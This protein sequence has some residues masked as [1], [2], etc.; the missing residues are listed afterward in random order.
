VLQRFRGELQLLDEAPK[1][2][3]GRNSRDS[4]RPAF[5]GGA[6]PIDGDVPF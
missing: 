5:S 1:A 3:G 6:D 4:R 2:G